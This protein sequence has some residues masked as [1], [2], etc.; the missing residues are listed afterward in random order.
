MGSARS[1]LLH[2]LREL[3][4]CQLVSGCAGRP[5]SQGGRGAG[6]QRALH[7]G[8]NWG[9]GSPTSGTVHVAAELQGERSKMQKEL[10]IS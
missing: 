1:P 10:Q 7:W 2:S 6:C 9:V 3:L 8:V 4:S 5:G